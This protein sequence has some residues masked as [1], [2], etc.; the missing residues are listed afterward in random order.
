MTLLPARLRAAGYATHQ[1]GESR[2]RRRVVVPRLGTV[3]QRRR[4]KDATCVQGETND[5]RSF[6]V[7]VGTT[8]EV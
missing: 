6:L 4:L 1:I 3:A 7:D 2:R 5:G 8:L